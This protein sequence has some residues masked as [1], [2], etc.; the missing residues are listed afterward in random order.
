M[1]QRPAR[2]T[3]SDL[4]RHART[5][6]SM[7]SAAR[8]ALM[9]FARGPQTFEKSASESGSSKHATR[10]DR[11]APY[12][13]TKPAR[14]RVSGQRRRCNPQA[15]QSERAE[16]D[17][18]QRRRAPQPLPVAI[19]RSTGIAGARPIWECACRQTTSSRGESRG[20]RPL[21][22]RD[23]ATGLGTQ[24]VP[25]AHQVSNRSA[26]FRGIGTPGCLRRSWVLRQAR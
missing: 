4:R 26:A 16:R 6:M 19:A 25:C 14:I 13:E 8:A 17:V 20:P 11:A 10:S 24:P 9:D 22:R 2:S 23:R 12:A 15:S 21:H 1:Y 7:R 5:S 3:S 18:R